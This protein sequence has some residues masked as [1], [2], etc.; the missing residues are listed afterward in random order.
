MHE[1]SPL[2]GKFSVCP[3]TLYGDIP[4]HPEIFQDLKNKQTKKIKKILQNNSG[5]QKKIPAC[6]KKLFTVHG[7]ILDYL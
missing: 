4:Q 3:E 6:V 5:Q 2:F 7:D 1:N